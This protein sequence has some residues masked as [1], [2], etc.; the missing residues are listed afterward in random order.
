MRFYEIFGKKQHHFEKNREN[1][2]E[3][4]Q[5]LQTKLT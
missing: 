3:I 4:P 1:N 2:K 5:T